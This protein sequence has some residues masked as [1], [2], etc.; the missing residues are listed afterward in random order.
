MHIE[1][2][3][4]HAPL[5]DALKSCGYGC[6]DVQVVAT[7]RVDPYAAGNDGQRGFAIVVNLDTG[8]RK[9]MV[10]SW[11]G[12]NMFAASPIDHATEAHELP[13]NGAVVK[14]QMGYPRTFATIYAHPS[15]VGRFL[16]SGEDHALSD[17][18]QQ[19]LYCFACIKGGEYRRDELRRRRVTDNC[20]TELVESGHL[21]RNRA[22]A[23]SITTKGKNARTINR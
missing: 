7:E 9:S 22:G 15:A 3:D 2:K 14:G 10:G 18:A 1:V 5:R 21:K 12:S 6:A 20:V 16:P 4:L 19:A 23:T 13:P 11:G 8:A 17:E